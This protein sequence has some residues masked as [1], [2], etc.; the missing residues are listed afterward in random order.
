MIAVHNLKKVYD[1]VAAVNDVS[2][3]VEDN[4]TM[5]LLGTSGCGKTTT[6]RM[7]NRLIKPD[8]G[9]IY[10]AGKNVEEQ[11]PEETRRKIGYVLQNHG[12]FP[13]YT[14]AENI[15]VVPQLLGWKKE[16]IRS[17]VYELLEK[18]HLP[19]AEFAGLY[20]GQLS[21]GQQ[22]RVGLA[23]ALAAKPP[24]LLMDEPFGALDPIT[25]AG[26]KKYLEELDEL[27]NKS[28]VLVTHDMEEAFEM[29]D[30]ICLM[31]KG[32]IVQAGT[33]QEL[34][35]HPVNDFASSFFREKRLVLELKTVKL[36]E[37]WPFLQGVNNEA[38]TEIDTTHSL[39]QAMEQVSAG[40]GSTVR[41]RNKN[42]TKHA[43][44]SALMNALTAYRQQ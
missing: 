43:G 7:I 15:A 37:L 2:F 44:Y 39:W 36:Y 40:K 12:L 22:Q 10:I 17:R 27:K 41:I 32:M 38:A 21:G 18:L 16:A 9:S 25:K 8:S 42:E 29:G 30:R 35:L 4:E 34:L 26:T 28:I 19:P 24:L 13:H 3:E 5:V 11:Q 1:H 20:P 23:R 14:V 31:D 6:L 33:P